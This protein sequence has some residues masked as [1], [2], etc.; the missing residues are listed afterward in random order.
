[1]LRRVSASSVLAL[2]IFALRGDVK[3]KVLSLAYE[4]TGLA[5]K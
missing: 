5:G 4:F 2:A 1:M 3:A